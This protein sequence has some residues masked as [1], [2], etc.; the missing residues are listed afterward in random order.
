MNKPVEPGVP[1]TI[2]DISAED[3]WK[4][5]SKSVR[6]VVEGTVR[7]QLQELIQPFRDDLASGKTDQAWRDAGAAHSDLSQYKPMIDAL[8]SRAGTTDPSFNEIEQY[9]YMA[10]GFTSKNESGATTSV[11]TVHPS[12]PPQHA[13]SSHPI[14][15]SEADKP[16]PR[17]LDENERTLARLSGQTPEEYL[18]LQ[19]MDEREVLTVEKSDD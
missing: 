17:E 11:P 18:R 8:L 13:P 16:K 6:E 19:D 15:P 10:V 2:E 1:V 3:F 12:A 9:Y 14:I 4:N 5:P 7:S